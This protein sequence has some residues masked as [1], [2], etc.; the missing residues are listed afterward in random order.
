MGD[1]MLLGGQKT[2]PAKLTKS[3]FVF[4]NSNIEK[5]LIDVVK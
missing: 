3:G 1:E 5:A 4:E 2:F